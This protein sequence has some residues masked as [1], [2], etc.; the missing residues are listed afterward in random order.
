MLCGSVKPIFS[1][2]DD[3][4]DIL[5]RML[6]RFGI[7]A[8]TVDI[9]Q[10]RIAQLPHLLREV[11]AVHPDVIL[12]QYPTE[13]FRHSLLPQA[14]ATLQTIA[15]LIVTLHEFALAHVLR[16]A[17]VGG[18]LLRAASIVTTAESE[19]QA[20][21]RWYPW[22][23]RR[24]RS[25]R[26]A[27]TIPGRPWQPDPVPTVV[28]FGQIRPGKGLEE[29][30]ACHDAL[31]PRFPGVRFVMIGSMVPQFA[32]YF[33]RMQLECKNRGIAIM[34]GLS[35][36]DVAD[37]LSHAT[38]ALLPIQGGASLRRTSV[39]AA[40]VCGLPI[41]TL[42]G[43]DTPAE[44]HAILPPADTLSRVI[45]QAVAILSDP[46]ARQAAHERSIRIA[47]LVGWDEIAARF[48]DVI[49]ALP[50]SARAARSRAT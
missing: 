5:T 20:L 24:V 40:A 29:F 41:A 10:W 48:I 39:L 26:I 1:G 35:D 3:Y 4:N 8:V 14:F 43:S 32:D 15:P 31:E 23:R 42:T 6:C 45:D 7:D 18:L 25:I 11:A 36:V 12:M 19:T 13:A 21:L 9:G 44:L 33:G 50:R 27:S 49:D 38:L 22:L 16:R 46:A 17:A 28:S 47:A 34:T 2:V 30:L 37:Q